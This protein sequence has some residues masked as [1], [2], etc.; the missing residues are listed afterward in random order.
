[1]KKTLLVLALLMGGSVVMA[2][3]A[4]ADLKELLGGKT[5]STLGNL[6]EGVFTKT[7]IDVKDLAGTYESTGSA[8]TFKSENALTK[9]GGV[10]AAAAIEAQLDPYYKKAG[11]TGA[12]FACDEAGNFTLKIK[13]ITLKGVATKNEDGT[14]EFNF[15]A[16]GK[17][18]LGSITTYVQKTPTNLEIM[19]DATKLKKMLSLISGTIGGSIVKNVGKILD[20]YDGACMGFG[21]K[22]TGAA[23]STESNDAGSIIPATPE[24]SDSTA[25]PSSGLGNLLKNVLKR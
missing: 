12:V 7:N 25:S 18:S 6:L 1:M 17:I 14:F 23:P 8:V 3:S 5:G 10:A 9:A 16:F 19:F 4:H 15:Q 22:K 24:S 20:S 13:K 2:P 21:F 11:L